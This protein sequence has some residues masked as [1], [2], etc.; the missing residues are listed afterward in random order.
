MN[1]KLRFFMMA[2]LCAMLNVAWG[3]TETI[4]TAT[5][6][7]INATYTDGWSTTG[8][9]K[10]RNDCI[11]IGSGENITSPSFDFTKYSKITITFKGR[12]YGSLT[13]SK[14]TVD[15]SISGSS[16]GTID[17]T[18]SSVGEVDGSIEFTP[19][20]KMTEA[21][22]VFTCTNATSAGST[23]GAGIGSITI[24]GT[25]IS[26]DPFIN[27]SS[28]TIEAGYEGVEGE[29]TF[30]HNK[31]NPSSVVFIEFYEADGT[32]VI[33]DANEPSWLTASIERNDGTG[34]G[35]VY[36]SIAKNEGE[37]RTLYFKLK[38]N[39]TSGFIYSDL[40]TITQQKNTPGTANNPYTVAQAIEFIETLEGSTSPTEVYVKGIV[41]QVDSYNSTYNSITYWISD[42]GTTNN[43]ME[44]YSGK[45]LEGAGFTA[46]TDLMVSDEVVVCGNV[47]KYNGIPEF[48]KNNY[49]VSFKRSDDIVST[50]TFTP[51]AG[52]VKAGTTLTLATS[53]EVD[54][55]EYSTGNENWTVYTSPITISEAVTIYARAKKGEKYSEVVSAA[56]TIKKEQ[57]VVTVED[58]K[59]TFDLTKN[60]WGFPVGSSNGKKDEKSYLANGY[61]LKVSATT[62]YYFNNSGYLMLGK[63]GSNLTLPKFD[64]PVSEIEVEGRSGASTAVKQNIYVGENAASTETTGATSTNAYEIASDYQADGNIYTLKVTSNHNTQIT[65]IIVYKVMPTLTIN[66]TE[67]TVPAVGGNGALT[68]TAENFDFTSSS[69]SIVFCDPETGETTEKPSWITTTIAPNSTIIYN[70]EANSETTSRTATFRLV[71]MP[72]GVVKSDLITI[73]QEGYVAP[74][75]FTLTVSEAGADGKGSYY[76][77]MSDLGDGNFTVPEGVTVYSVQV[78]NGKLYTFDM[79]KTIPGN[80]FNRK[81]AYLVEASAPGTYK[82][83]PTTNAA[84]QPSAMTFLFASTEGALTS[85]PNSEDMTFKYYKLSRK[86][87][88]NGQ[89]VAN[90][91]GFYWGAEE[92]AAFTMNA[93]HTAF[94]AVPQYSEEEESPEALLINFDEDTDGIEGINAAEQ[95]SKEVYTL[96]GVRVKGGNLPKG[97]YIINGRKQVVK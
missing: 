41:S 44:V 50:P 42:D 57:Q 77:T 68:I 20:S 52:E 76:A 85:V 58:D 91:V 90:S 32:T 97:I 36:Y 73:T 9:G 83:E 45:G 84:D 27:V 11:I 67:V 63:S 22:L 49:L 48:D 38:V 28:T 25:A 61:T 59:I 96:S 66:P 12:R 80:A 30:T 35:T 86:Q 60:E 47:K 93:N 43:Q 40:I 51:A 56:Y 2:L 24:T 7:G 75:T 17:I 94:L 5:F 29:L 88:A 1:Q 72:S 15:A 55:I 64:F 16:V 71:S 65:K 10:G 34:T 53:Y 13:G 4:A 39:S 18:K 74:S 54:G 6:D 23:H 37:A 81:C 21:V 92:G 95:Q 31:L 26:D 79:G 78:G 70:V 46:E 69:N 89:P 19:T 14:A 87:D 62:S 82:F 3:A 33:E 8:T